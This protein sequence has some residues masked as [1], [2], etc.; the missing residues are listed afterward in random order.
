MCKHKLLWYF[1]VVLVSFCLG[2]AFLG[3]MSTR[4]IFSIKQETEQWETAH[5]QSCCLTIVQ[6]SIKIQR[7]RNEYT[8]SLY[9]LNLPG[10]ILPVTCLLSANSWLADYLHFILSNREEEVVFYYRFSFLG[11]TVDL[12][13]VHTPRNLFYFYFYFFRNLFYIV[14]HLLLSLKGCNQSSR[15]NFLKGLMG[16]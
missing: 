2:W 7:V 16:M 3:T 9:A 13:T 10:L 14:R 11:H 8:L 15:N 1:I 6:N 5:L 12:L 4:T